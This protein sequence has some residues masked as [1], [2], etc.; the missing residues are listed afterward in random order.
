MDTNKY[1]KI[2]LLLKDK[3][4]SISKL[5]LEN[6]NYQFSGNFIIISTIDNLF[7]EIF[8]IFNL[9]EVKSYKIYEIKKS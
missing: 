1:A 5:T 3:N 4:E 7:H 2:E 6:C 9:S 8:Q